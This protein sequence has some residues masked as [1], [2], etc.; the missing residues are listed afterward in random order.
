MIMTVYLWHITVQMAVGGAFY[1]TGDFAFRLAPGSLEWW[2]SRPLWIGLLI[3]VLVPVALVLSAFERRARAADA[4]TPAAARQI[5]GAVMACLGISFLSLWGL[6]GGPAA[7]VDEAALALV[8][9]GAFLS[10]LIFSEKS[11]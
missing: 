2:L 10:G 9:V 6:G 1:L 5:T 3:L 8:V 4:R 11:R 7:W